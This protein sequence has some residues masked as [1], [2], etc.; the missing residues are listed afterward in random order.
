MGVNS[1]NAS[2]WK[3]LP[4]SFRINK[5]LAIPIVSKLIIQSLQKKNM[6]LQVWYKKQLVEVY[7][8]PHV[9]DTLAREIPT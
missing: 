8:T 1:F 2:K 7:S 5:S 3:N 6:D 9:L 4:I